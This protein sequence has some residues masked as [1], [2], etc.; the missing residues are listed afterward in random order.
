MNIN[1]T[2]NAITF[3]VEVEPWADVVDGGTIDFN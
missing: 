2:L 3:D 1:P